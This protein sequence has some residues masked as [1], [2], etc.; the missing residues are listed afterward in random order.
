MERRGRGLIGPYS[1]RNVLT[2]QRR[3][4]GI[5]DVGT[6]DHEKSTVD[7]NLQFESIVL[8]VTGRI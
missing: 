6:S 2:N 4:G 5:N 3:F 7:I 1:E 8:D